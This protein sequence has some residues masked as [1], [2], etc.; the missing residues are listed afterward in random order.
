MVEK[1]PRVIGQQ[2]AQHVQRLGDVSGL[3]SQMLCAIWPNQRTAQYK[4]NIALLFEHLGLHTVVRVLGVQVKVK[5]QR[6][7]GNRL[8]NKAVAPQEVICR[9]VAVCNCQLRELR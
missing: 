3:R 9:L 7:D 8:W 5:V 1:Y 4:L 2:H 6:S